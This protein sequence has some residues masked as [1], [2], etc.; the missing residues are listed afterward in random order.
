MTTTQTVSSVPRTV[1]N[2]P[3]KPEIVTSSLVPSAKSGSPITPTAVS[4]AAAKST[5]GGGRRIKRNAITVFSTIPFH[6]MY[7]EQNP[8]PPSIA[9]RKFQNFLADL[10]RLAEEQPPPVSHHVWALV[11]QLIKGRVDPET[12]TRKL[13]SALDCPPQS[14]LTPFLKK[15][16]PILAKTLKPGDI[17]VVVVRPSPR[18]QTLHVEAHGNRGDQPQEPVCCK[19]QQKKVPDQLL[20]CGIGDL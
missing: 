17:K 20:V 6:G 5:I 13:Q 3:V 8:M 2:P 9:K 19:K 1:I 15:I 18:A 7:T 16:L 14:R 4:V 11:N 12:F 10:L